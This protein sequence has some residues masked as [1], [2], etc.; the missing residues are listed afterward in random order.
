[1]NR[2][3]RPVVFAM[4]PD[5][6]F[7]FMKCAFGAS[8]APTLDTNQSKGICNITRN[9]IAFTGTTAGASPTVSSVNTFVGLYNGMTVT[10]TNIPASTTISSMNAGAGTITLSQ[11]ANGVN[12]GLT[13]VGGQYTIQLGAQAGVRFDTY[14]KLLG[15][16]LCWDESASQGGASTAASSP[17]APFMFQVGN[18]VSVKTVPPTV[19]ANLT[20][21]TFQVQFGTLSAGTF[22]AADPRNGDV[23]R[24]AIQLCRSGAI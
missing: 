21:A 23:V 4:E 5:V 10:G 19:A 13:A 9:S 16:N 14:N 22:V 11:N 3:A 20:D 2:F 8:G 1:M 7:L 6:V 12:A 18:N 15:L 17:A 24:I